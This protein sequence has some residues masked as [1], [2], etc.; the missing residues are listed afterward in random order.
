MVRSVEVEVEGVDWEVEDV[1]REVVVV[2]RGGAVVDVVGGMVVT[3]GA[4]G[5]GI[6]AVLVFDGLVLVVLDTD[7]VGWVVVGSE[8]VVV[9]DAV[10]GNGVGEVGAV[11]GEEVGEGAKTGVL[12][13][14]IWKTAPTLFIQSIYSVTLV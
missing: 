9:G 5:L 11:G 14:E 8:V 13:L 1:D 6:I 12:I 10:T 2:T 3:I 4:V 7:V